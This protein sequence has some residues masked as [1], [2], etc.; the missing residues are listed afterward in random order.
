[1]RAIVIGVGTP[2]SAGENIGSTREHLGA[3]AT[4]LWAP[5]TSLR[6]SACAG[7]KSGSAD[8]WPGSTWEH[9]QQVWDLLESQLSCL[10]KATSPLGTLLVR[11]EIIATTSRSMIFKTHVF[12]L[13]SHLC[14]Y[15]ATHLH[16]VYLD[17]LQAVR[18]S[19]S[20]CTWKWRSSELGDTLRGRDR[21]SV[22]MHLEAVI[23]RTW[24]P[25]SCYFR[26]S[27]GDCDCASLGMHLEAVTVR[28]CR[29]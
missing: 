21:A 8:N 24:W 23:V 22:E 1:M 3:A 12:S 19:N 11:L 5:T 17:W 7:N 27:L 13:Y 26:D 29:P 28:T 2:R 6:T 14:I 15:I 18:E 10:G 20:R 9:W 4:S 16:M 25:W